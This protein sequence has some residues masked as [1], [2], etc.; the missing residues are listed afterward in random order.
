MSTLSDSQLHNLAH[1]RVEFRAHLI[2]YCITNSALW[3]IWFITG[4][5]YAWPLFP[6]IGWGIGITFHYIFDYR[7]AS[8]LSD[9]EEFRKLKEEAERKRVN[10]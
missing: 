5:G 10:Q 8:L 7:P 3:V 2:V 9:E 4:K 6:M 1:K